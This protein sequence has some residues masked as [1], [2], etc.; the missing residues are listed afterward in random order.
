MLAIRTATPDDIPALTALLGQL[1]SQ[2]AEFAPDTKIQA[3]GLAAIIA[4]PAAGRIMVAKEGGRPIAMVNLLYTVSTALGG[5][6]AILEDMVVDPG[7]RGDGIGARLLQAAL[8]A[9][10][11]DGCLR[12]TLLTD[13]DNERAHRFYE[14]HG[15][16]RS[17]MVPYRILL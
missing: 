1:F 7:S 8:D 4:E 6:V 10:R 15:F 9:A 2:E 11:A 13:G 3:R 17:A 5:R 16:V 14:R 12:V